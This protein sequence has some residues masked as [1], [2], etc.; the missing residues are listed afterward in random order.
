MYPAPSSASEVM[1]GLILLSSIWRLLFNLSLIPTTNQSG[2]F[3]S[4]FDVET[5]ILTKP[6][7][8]LFKKISPG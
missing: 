2:I 4:S 8:P 6:A 3:S 1:S 7:S 5:S